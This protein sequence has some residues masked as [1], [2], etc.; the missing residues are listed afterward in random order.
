MSV[1][2]YV[3]GALQG[4]SPIP[5]V[6]VLSIHG[7]DLCASPH[8]C[9]AEVDQELRQVVLGASAANAWSDKCAVH[10][11]SLGEW[12]CAGWYAVYRRRG[13]RFHLESVHVDRYR[14]G[15]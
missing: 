4:P 5:P 6:P 14:Q 15:L 1:W 13:R 3:D 11:F 12:Q 2:Q 9:V 7:A 8:H 10:R